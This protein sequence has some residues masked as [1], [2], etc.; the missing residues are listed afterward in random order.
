MIV[1]HS[2]LS[3][4]FGFSLGIC[5]IRDFASFDTLSKSF[6]KLDNMII[7]FNHVICERG[8]D[9]LRRACGPNNPNRA[10]F[11]GGSVSRRI[12]IQLCITIFSSHD[13]KLSL[14]NIRSDKRLMNRKIKCKGGL[15]FFFVITIRATFT[16]S[17]R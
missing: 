6:C 5:F 1:V 4:V 12:K 13:S 9:R 16:E 14:A 2:H 17:R 8:G 3:L 15:S 7:S 11:F 10:V